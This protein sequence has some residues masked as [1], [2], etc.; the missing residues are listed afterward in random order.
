MDHADIFLPLHCIKHNDPHD[1]GLHIQAWVYKTRDWSGQNTLHATGGDS[2]TTGNDE[3]SE[4][5]TM[6]WQCLYE[7]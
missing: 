3:M 7:I 4:G 6:E 1:R 5:L 2:V